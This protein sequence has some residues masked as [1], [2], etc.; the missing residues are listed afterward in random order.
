MESAASA[1][2]A[3][4]LS[5]ILVGEEGIIEDILQLYQGHTSCKGNNTFHSLVNVK[6]IHRLSVV[7]KEHAAMDLPAFRRSL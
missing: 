1:S 6:H 7:A 4:N 3:S 2:K 5:T